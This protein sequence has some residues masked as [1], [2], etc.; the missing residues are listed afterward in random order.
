[1][2]RKTRVAMAVFLR[3]H[4]SLSKK[5]ALVWAERVLLRQ[6]RPI[7]GVDGSEHYTAGEVREAAAMLGD[8]L[9]SGQQPGRA[10]LFECLRMVRQPKLQRAERLLESG[11][12]RPPTL[13]EYMASLGQDD[14][15]NNP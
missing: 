2:L 13:T 3:E 9:S 12:S 5:D 8:R 11:T 6:P 15:E 1:M 7:P 4:L 10:D 14:E